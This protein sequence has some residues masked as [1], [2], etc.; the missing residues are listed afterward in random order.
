MQKGNIN[1]YW[2]YLP[3]GPDMH[4]LEDLQNDPKFFEYVGAKDL[5]VKVFDNQV[6]EG[7]DTFD[8][9]KN[10]KE[11]R[12]LFVKNKLNDIRD[13]AIYQYR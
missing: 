3:E 7:S 10:W 6:I 1:G 9:E 8:I 2:S 11:E 5:S 4:S 13:V 12:L